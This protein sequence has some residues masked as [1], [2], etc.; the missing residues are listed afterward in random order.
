MA[1]A[2]DVIVRQLSS[3]VDAYEN[4]VASA[5][6]RDDHRLD[7]HAARHLLTRALA[8]IERTAPPSS[9]YRAQAQS[10]M[11]ADGWTG[12]K[13]TEV[14]AIVRALRDDYADGAM[15][16]V[17]ELVHA[18]LFGDLLDMAVELHAKR[19]LGPAAVVAGSVLEEHLRKLA[20]KHGVNT[21]DHNDRSKSVDRLGVELRDAAVVSEVQRKTVVAWYAQRSEAAH[22]RF[23]QLV[24]GEVERMIDGVRDFVSRQTA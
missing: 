16:T 9:A 14:V 23:D 15:R 20:L 5:D 18:D 10:V 2:P 3:V 4:E 21:L 12:F 22:G 11:E 7:E 6:G 1:L 13:A 19:F 17:E 8:A 24:D